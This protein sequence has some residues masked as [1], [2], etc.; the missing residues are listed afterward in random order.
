M[1]ETRVRGILTS[2]LPI[3]WAHVIRDPLS[4]DIPQVLDHEM[5]K[6]VLRDAVQTVGVA[7]PP[8]LESAHSAFASAYAALVEHNKKL[9]D[10]AERVF[11]DTDGH[12]TA[13]L[14]R[15]AIPLLADASFVQAL[16]SSSSRP[17]RPRSG[18]RWALAQPQPAGTRISPGCRPVLVRN[19][20]PWSQVNAER[21]STRAWARAAATGACAHPGRSGRG[22][23]GFRGRFEHRVC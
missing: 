7:A 12:D 15:E 23:T 4:A 18:S 13:A 8:E 2:V 16:Q 10:I 17:W 5:R 1:T 9:L 19:L 21:R 14:N 20:V 6:Q 22:A 3:D 11:A